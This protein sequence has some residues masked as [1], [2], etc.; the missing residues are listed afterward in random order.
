MRRRLEA[1]A[2][3]GR[4]RKTDGEV[5]K[6]ANRY[7]LDTTA[8]PRARAKVNFFPNKLLLLERVPL[9]SNSVTKLHLLC[10]HQQFNH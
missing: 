4:K 10:S 6:D 9:S 8:A 7:D 5:V 3:P 1:L 2:T